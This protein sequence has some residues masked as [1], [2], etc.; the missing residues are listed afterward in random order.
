MNKAHKNGFAILNSTQKENRN[1]KNLHPTRTHKRLSKPEFITQKFDSIIDKFFVEKNDRDKMYEGYSLSEKLANEE[2]LKRMKN[3]INFQRSQRSRENPL[4]IFEFAEVSQFFYDLKSIK[5]D[6][7]Y[8]LETAQLDEFGINDLQKVPC[9]VNSEINAE[10]KKISKLE[11]DNEKICFID[12]E[13]EKF[14]TKRLKIIN[15]DSILRRI[16]II[17]P[18]TKYFSSK[19]IKHPSPVDGNIAPGNSLEIE[20]LFKGKSKIN[21][22]DFL[23]IISEKGFFYV[24]LEGLKE[25]PKINLDNCLLAETKV[26]IDKV[27]LS[28]F[29]SK[30][31]NKK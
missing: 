12:F 23:T 30:I 1:I 4:R 26:L 20:I 5:K 6:R 16:K 21:H 2:V 19:I 22:L 8:P 17:P 14:L 29:K 28:K 10:L 11:V 31:N 13:P 25:V 15:T 7:E 27:K 3:L 18:F 9:K 24:R